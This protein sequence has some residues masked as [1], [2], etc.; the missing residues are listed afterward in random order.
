MFNA[1]AQ[2]G[3][4]YVARFQALGARLF[5][6]EFLDE[7]PEVVARTI[8]MYR[9][10]LAGEIGGAALVRELKLQHQL[11]V[12]RGSLDKGERPTTVL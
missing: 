10:L 3:A 7:S 1:L 9:R 12:T 6:I 5:R 8:G 2:T 4:E 11:G